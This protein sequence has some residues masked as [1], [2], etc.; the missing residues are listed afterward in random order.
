VERITALEV[1]M[2]SLQLS[3]LT[4]MK[5]TEKRHDDMSGKLDELLGLRNKGVGA[6]WLASALAGTGIIGAILSFFSWWKG[7]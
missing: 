2:A 7:V 3:M 6:F 1:Q 4:H 5:E